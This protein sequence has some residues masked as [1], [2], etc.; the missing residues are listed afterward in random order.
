MFARWIEVLTT[1]TPVAVVGTL[2]CCAIPIMLVTVGA[3][4]VVA[5]LV[6]AAPWLVT[7]TRHK[8]WIF[9]LSG[10]LLAANY[11]GLYRSG[12]PACQPG[13][14]CHPTHPVGKWLRRMYWGSVALYG[15]GFGAAY[16]SVPVARALGY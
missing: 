13:G 2:M 10:L 7:L 6:S 8:E 1:I 9:V 5:S 3:G 16:L 15:V 12:G 4:S 14:V 11:W